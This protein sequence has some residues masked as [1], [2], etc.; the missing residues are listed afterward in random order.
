MNDY[1]MVKIN[2][3]KIKEA[4]NLLRDQNLNKSSDEVLNINY[5]EAYL[6]IFRYIFDILYDQKFNKPIEGAQTKKNQNT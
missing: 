3:S 4:Y 2:L 5:Q 6:K 1:W